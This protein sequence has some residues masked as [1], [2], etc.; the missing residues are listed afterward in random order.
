MLALNK[1]RKI[2]FMI[3]FVFKCYI[4]GVLNAVTFL[5]S[6]SQKYILDLYHIKLIKKNSNESKNE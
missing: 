5:E 1:S 3:F 2:K 6:I 4:I